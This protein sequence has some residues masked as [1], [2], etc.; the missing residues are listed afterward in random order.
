MHWRGCHKANVRRDVRSPPP[1]S[2]EGFRNPS[3]NGVGLGLGYQ[4]LPLARPQNV[5]PQ[6]PPPPRKP[7]LSDCF[8][9]SRTPRPKSS[10]WC[11]C[12]CLFLVFFQCFR[13][14]VLVFSCA[15]ARWIG[16]SFCTQRPRPVEDNITVTLGDFVPGQSKAGFREP[17]SMPQKG[18]AEWELVIADILLVGMLNG[19]PSFYGSNNLVLTCSFQD[20]DLISV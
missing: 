7:A 3:K 19:N 1:H 11:V 8:C 18:G 14:C 6:N 13:A 16:G 2:A 5:Y 20:H 10:R 9:T 4:P 12:V 17:R 15:C